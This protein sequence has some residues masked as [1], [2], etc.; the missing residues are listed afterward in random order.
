MREL[1]P[2]GL[3]NLDADLNRGR[4]KSLKDSIGLIVVLALVDDS[5]LVLLKSLRG[6]LDWQVSQDLLITLGDLPVG[7]LDLWH[8]QDLALDLNGVSVDDDAPVLECFL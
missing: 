8:G 6:V 7:Q 5:P 3:L 4:A 1:D 2:V